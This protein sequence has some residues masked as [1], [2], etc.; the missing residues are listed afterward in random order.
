ML[1]VHDKLHARENNM[2]R[3]LG[4][5]LTAL[6]FF[7]QSA[8]AEV[9]VNQSVQMNLEVF[10]PC[11]NQGAGELVRLSGPLHVLITFTA[12]GRTF[13]G[14]TQF[15]L[16]GISGIGVDSGERYNGTGSTQDHFSGTFIKGQSS[17]SFIN[18]FRIIGQKSANNF[19]L[20]ENFHVTFNANAVLATTHDNFSVDCR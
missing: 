1:A 13:S 15:Q 5:V 6:A 4:G 16:Q 11:A 14:S 12:N 3:L 2:K 7:A 9:V 20:H 17:A 8:Q 19:V 10:V 18:N